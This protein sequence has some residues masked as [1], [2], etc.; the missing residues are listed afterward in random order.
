M[1]KA[2]IL[3]VLILMG[4]NSWAQIRE[5]QTTRIMSTAG[6][7]VASILSTEA[8]ILNPAASAFFEESSFS[9]Q[10]YRTT[11]E[12]KADVRD[13]TPEP[14]PGNNRSQGLFLSD[15]SGPIKGGTAYIT[16]EENDFERQR[17]VLHGAAPMS[18]TSAVGVTYSYIQ[19]RRPP[20]F[21][22]RNKI[23]HQTSIGITHIL[24]Q[25]TVL[26]VLILDP[27]RTTPGEERAWAGFQY[28]LADRFT[29]LG[30]VGARYTRDVSQYYIW[31]AA[32][33]MN[34]FSDFFVRFGQFYDNVQKFKGTGWGMG[35]VGPRFGVEFAQKH[36]EQFKSGYYVYEGESIL[37]S[38]L[39]AVIK[40]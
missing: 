4:H 35:W 29:L 37:D 34:I 39:S 33:Q 8:A 12:Q 26:A 40:F 19:D 6:T 28:T 15:N 30:D 25:D 38:S 18:Q 1:M 31:R 5:F 24:D 13:A 9:Y 11:L 16:Q 27:T 23:H 2:I 10:S 3:T 17:M 20:T 7:G 21:K 36:S 22:K 32:V 14:F